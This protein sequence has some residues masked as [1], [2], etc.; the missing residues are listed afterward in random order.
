MAQESKMR[1]NIIVI[2]AVIASFILGGSYGYHLA[3]DRIGKFIQSNA[4]DN[5]LFHYKKSSEII[6]AVEQGND[7]LAIQKLESL[8]KSEA[9]L[10]QSCLIDNCSE[11]LRK[12]IESVYKP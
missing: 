3:D 10:F 7:A 1:K 2:V 8:K 12:K 6:L 9:V 4:I 5:A 11:D